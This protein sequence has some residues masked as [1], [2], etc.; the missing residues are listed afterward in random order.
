MIS[1]YWL[2]IYTKGDL[3]NDYNII[4]SKTK[5]NISIFFKIYNNKNILTIKKWYNIVA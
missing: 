4:M 5:K 2:F 1:G 3:K